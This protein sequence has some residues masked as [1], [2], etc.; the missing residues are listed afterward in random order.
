VKTQQSQ[1]RLFV[2]VS[3]GLEPWL[4]S[5]LRE[6]GL[7][8]TSAAG[9]AELH[10]STEQLWRLHHECRLAEHIRVRLRSFRAR[11]FDEL[12]AGLQR[13]PWHA[14]LSAN[15][16]VDIHATC[17]RSRL[18]H[19]D[20]VAERVQTA[21]MQRTR[22]NAEVS[23]LDEAST[24]QAIYVRI[25]GDCVQPAI[26]ASG[27]PLHRRGR[28]T[29]VTAAPLRET[30]AAALV[31]VANQASSPTLPRL[32][33]PFCGSGCILF[34]WAESRLELSAGRDRCFAFEH[35]PIHDAAAYGAWQQQR[36]ARVPAET[37]ALGSDVDERALEAARANAS[38]CS[39]ERHCTWHHGDFESFA[40]QVPFGTPII[41][42]PPYGVR[43]GDRNATVQLMQRFESLLARRTDLRPAVVLLPH[44]NRHWKPKL[45]WEA[46]AR[47]Y[48]GG[49][50]VQILRLV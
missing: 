47:F 50:Q 29:F 24:P 15:Q 10:A 44:P 46:V 31:R 28:R 26:D 18:W 32:W 25:T 23:G 4:V 17:H 22:T 6:L 33:D 40:D 16:K 49:L 21:L 14:Y 9:G 1:Y 19:S 7:T 20:A 13:L 48:N 2:A 38:R 45:A 43:L 30:L 27:E 34:E 12:I 3:P 35:W 11:H 39:L 5:E 37:L 36:R 8:A 41:T 42:N